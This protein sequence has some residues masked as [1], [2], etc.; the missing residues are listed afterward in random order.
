MK[1]RKM[2][3]KMTVDKKKYKIEVI[4]NRLFIN[5]E[6]WND[7]LDCRVDQACIN[8]DLKSV[9]YIFKAQIRTFRHLYK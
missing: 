3:L 1:V 8:N 6:I 7:S 9:K 4:G 2:S 5:N